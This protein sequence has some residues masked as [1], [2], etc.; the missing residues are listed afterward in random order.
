VINE[1]PA[2]APPVRLAEAVPPEK[3]DPPSVEER[4]V[5]RPAAEAPEPP[6]ARS[7]REELVARMKPDSALPAQAREIERQAYDGVPEAQHDLAA[8]YTAGQGGVK[9]DYKRAAFWF[10]QS[11]DQGIANARY[12]LG[13]LYHQG[14]GVKADLAEAIKWYQAAAK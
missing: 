14:L 8:I 2:Q 5:A 12:N 13:V 11:A 1:E 7:S 10:R 4:T 3:T 6:A 9:Q